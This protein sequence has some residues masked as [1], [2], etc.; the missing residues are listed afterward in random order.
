M[1]KWSKWRDIT[2]DNLTDL[3]KWPGVYIIRLAN[4]GYS[5][6]IGRFLKKDKSGL[7]A[8]GESGDLARRIKEFYH[9][10]NRQIFFRHSAGDRLFFVLAYHHSS[11]STSN[12]NS[13]VQFKFMRVKNKIEAQNKEAKLLMEYFIRYGELP[14][15]NNSLPNKSNWPTP[16]FA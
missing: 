10:Y 9:A 14:P 2:M 8:I 11:W 16:K 7:L 6:P 13:T 5:T 12:Q 3:G 4:V 1:S 15:L